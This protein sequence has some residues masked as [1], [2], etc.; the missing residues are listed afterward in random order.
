MVSFLPPSPVFSSYKLAYSE[1]FYCCT[2]ESLLARSG[3]ILK[4]ALLLEDECY[5]AEAGLAVFLPPLAPAVPFGALEALPPACPNLVTAVEVGLFISTIGCC[6]ASSFLRF[7]FF[8]G[9]LPSDLQTESSS[10]EISSM[11]SE[12]SAA[13]LFPLFALVGFVGA[14]R[15]ALL[16]QLLSSE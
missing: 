11:M 4:L 13:S 16:V 6:L 9:G 3:L 15:T 10:S 1:V 7:L 2:D 12:V 8:R 14:L 5:F